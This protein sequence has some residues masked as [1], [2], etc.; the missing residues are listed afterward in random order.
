MKKISIALVGL[1][2]LTCAAFAAGKAEFGA[3][4]FDTTGMNKT[5]KPGDDFFEYANGTWSKNAVTP[6]D[7][8]PPGV[9][10][11]LQIL[12]EKGMGAIVA[13]LQAKPADKRTAEE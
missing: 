9:F 10:Q 8:A 7:R 4:G 6:A 13:E 2:C 11:E 3:W 12:S 1:T 5:V